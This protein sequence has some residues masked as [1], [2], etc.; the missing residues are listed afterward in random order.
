MVP[1]L[2]P[3]L[4]AAVQDL[5]AGAGGLGDQ[6]RQMS[7]HFRQGGSSN[8]TL[9][10]NAYLVARLPATYASV[11]AC[12]AELLLRKPHFAPQTLLDA[13]S[14]PGTAGWA[15]AEAF[16]SLSG[17]TFVDNNQEF[18]SLAVNLAKHSDHKA[19]QQVV[20][21][22]AD[23][24]QF[25]PTMAA[26]L[27]IAAYALAELPLGRIGAA[28]RNLWAASKDVLMIIEP[29]TPQGYARIIEARSLLIAEGAHIA[30][31]C[32]HGN[33]CPLNPPD[34]CHFS[35]RLPRSRE[36]MHAKKATV[37]FEDEK[38]TYLI[39]SRSHSQTAGARILAPPVATKAET[40]FKLCAE[41]GL[42]RHGVATR[43]K[44]EHRRIRK[45]GWGDLF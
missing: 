29:G 34:W 6:T 21:Q 35:V 27:V 12:I 9:D 5:V 3:D 41:N 16:P 26:D 15:A 39:A 42:T 14:G 38:Y 33:A 7:D 32:P 4:K 19:L 2:P 11:S 24:S 37:P 20:A 31:P 40:R 13:G 36:H 25:L 10:F 45:L 8:A 22:T 43:D 17:L 18:L 23:F 28:T 30:A 1:A 44:A